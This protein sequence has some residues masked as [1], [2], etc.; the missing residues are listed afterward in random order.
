MSPPHN[1]TKPSGATLSSHSP[2]PLSFHVLRQMSEDP[3]PGTTT[4]KDGDRADSA[5]HGFSL[6]HFTLIS[7]ALSLSLPSPSSPFSF[8][9]S[10][11]PGSLC[12]FCDYRTFTRVSP[13]HTPHVT[14]PS[15]ATRPGARWSLR[16]EVENCSDRSSTSLSLS[17][18]LLQALTRDALRSFTRAKPIQQCKVPKNDKKDSS[19]N[20][21]KLVAKGCGGWYK[22]VSTI[23]YISLLFIYCILQLHLLDL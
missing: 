2:H 3:N 15:A 14:P 20:I 6:H 19:N 10:Q 11:A 18:A 9:P 4:G 8:L 16:L 7:P 5:S 22:D 21:G 12:S 23:R 17:E 1:V 13:R